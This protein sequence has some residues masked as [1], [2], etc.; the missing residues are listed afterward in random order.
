MSKHRMIDWTPDRFKRLCQHYDRAV[1]EG[2]EDF[3][4]RNLDENGDV[5]LVTA[6]AKYLI[7]YLESKGMTKPDKGDP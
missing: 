7:E 6:Y 2:R 1:R 4:I 3:V 5:T